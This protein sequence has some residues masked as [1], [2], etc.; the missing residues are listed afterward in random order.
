[1]TR[2]RRMLTQRFA[3][4]LP[5]TDQMVFRSR[6]SRV[7]LLVTVFDG[8]FFHGIFRGTASAKTAAETKLD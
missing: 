3:V 8:Y 2:P 4:H 5:V 6:G 1:M 7:V